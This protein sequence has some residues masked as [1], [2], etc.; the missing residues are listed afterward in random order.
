MPM[1]IGI[2]S[3]VNIVD[4]LPRVGRMKRFTILSISPV[5][6]VGM[7]AAGVGGFGVLGGLLNNELIILLSFYKWDIHQ[8]LEIFYQRQVWLFFLL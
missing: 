6:G 5:S 3:P 7:G 2:K 1:L 4:S 8:D